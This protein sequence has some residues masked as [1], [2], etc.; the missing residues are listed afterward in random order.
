VQHKPR[1]TRLA[2]VNIEGGAQFA[3]TIADPASVTFGRGQFMV[4]FQDSVDEAIH[5]FR[6]GS[7][8]RVLLALPKLLDWRAWRRVDQQALA[9]DLAI[10][11]AQVTRALLKLLEAG[12]IQRR[13]KR[14]QYDW[15][16]LPKLGWRGTASQYHQSVRQ[17]AA[18][19]EPEFKLGPVLLA[20]SM[21]RKVKN[22]RTMKVIP[23]SL[24][25]G[26]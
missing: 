17:H 9:D 20:E 13:G 11:R 24:V 25:D 4:L 3:A 22:L 15:R 2:V 5:R 1:Q 23:G 16:L 6:S 19:A 12:Y 7:T 8:L 21:E 10:D 26:S 18:E 14:G